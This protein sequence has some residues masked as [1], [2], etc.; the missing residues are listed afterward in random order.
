MT[1]NV[2]S[3]AEDEI[4]LGTSDG[5]GLGQQIDA[6][7]INTDTPPIRSLTS[8][9]IATLSP[10]AGTNNVSQMPQWVLQHILEVL[11]TGVDLLQANYT[12][13]L[14][15]EEKLTVMLKQRD[16]TAQ[17]REST[18]ENLKTQLCSLQD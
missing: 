1:A 10:T 11:N 2:T 9:E 4:Y 3:I 6:T 14:S 5:L 18:M 15:H 17:Q 7:I 13:V 8:T 12:A 16:D